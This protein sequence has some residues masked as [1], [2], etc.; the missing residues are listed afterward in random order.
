MCE[1]WTMGEMLIEFMRPR[2]DM[3]IF[4]TGEFIGPYPSA[5]DIY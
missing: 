5:R 2:A 4:A 1:V 3:Q